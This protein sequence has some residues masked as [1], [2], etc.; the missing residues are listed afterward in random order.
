M[1]ECFKETPSCYKC[2]GTPQVNYK[3]KLVVCRPCFQTHICEKGFRSNLRNSLKIVGKENRILVMFTGD[4]SSLMMCRLLADV[5]KDDSKEHKRMFIQ[6]KVVVVDFGPLMSSVGMFNESVRF[7][8]VMKGSLEFVQNLGLDT[9]TISTSEFIGDDRV[10]KVF[11]GLDRRGDFL[12]DFLNILQFNAMRFAC[13][14]FNVDRMLTPETS[15]QLSSRLFGLMCKGRVDE[16][17][18]QCLQV[19]ITR[20]QGKPIAVCRPLYERTNRDV[21]LFNYFNRT[22]DL[23]LRLIHSVV[24]PRPKIEERLPCQGSINTLLTEFVSSMQ[25]EY[26]STSTTVLK[27][28]EKLVDPLSDLAGLPQCFLCHKEMTKATEETTKVCQGCRAFIK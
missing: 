11:R 7:E 10:V 28:L 27:T 24:H 25:H 22:V 17:G 1:S 15:E 12:E 23:D 6:P 18:T 14:K 5:L 26:V 19:Y 20:W 8:Q 21:G 13:R 2:K 16:V 3:N 4:Q 9:E